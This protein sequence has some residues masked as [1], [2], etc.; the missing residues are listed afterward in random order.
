M[1]TSRG[2]YEEFTGVPTVIFHKKDPE[3]QFS[4]YQGIKYFAS[5]GAA[6]AASEDL[7]RGTSPKLFLYLALG[8]PAA[9]NLHN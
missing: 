8:P 6:G 7:A 1:D 3:P 9:P 5:Q 2:E 4:E